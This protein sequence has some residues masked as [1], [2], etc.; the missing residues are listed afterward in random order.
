MCI[1]LGIEVRTKQWSEFLCERVKRER[2]AFLVEWAKENV[3]DDYQ[4]IY[5]KSRSE[6]PMTSKENAHCYAEATLKILKKKR[7]VLGG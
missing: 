7:S 4:R 3:V 5:E 2:V 1:K 6:F